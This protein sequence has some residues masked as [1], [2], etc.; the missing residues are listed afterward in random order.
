MILSPTHLEPQSKP[1]LSAL[2]T[3]VIE[4]Q[5]WR[6]NLKMSRDRDSHLLQSHLSPTSG[7]LLR[8]RKKHRLDPV[9]FIPLNWYIVLHSRRKDLSTVLGLPLSPCILPWGQVPSSLCFLLPVH[10]HMS[11]GG[12]HSLS[13]SLHPSF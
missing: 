7:T 8:Q 2:L 13:C 11:W 1:F 9:T 10:Q 4:G 6:A 5:E 12:Q 3:R